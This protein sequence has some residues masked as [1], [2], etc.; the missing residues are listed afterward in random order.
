MSKM[1][2]YELLSPILLAATWMTLGTSNWYIIIRIKNNFSFVAFI[3]ILYSNV[4]FKWANYYSNDDNCYNWTN[5]DDWYNNNY[6]WQSFQTSRNVLPSLLPFYVIQITLVDYKLFISD[7]YY[8]SVNDDW[9]LK[10]QGAS[11]ENGCSNKDSIRGWYK[12]T[13]NMCKDFCKDTNFLQYHASTHCGCFKDCDF[14][15]PASEYR[16]KADIYERPSFGMIS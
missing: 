4:S 5:H 10:A 2:I 7:Q 9:I 13:L 14:K 15:R 12:A 11:N 3:S 16:S 1:K 8:F 6:Q